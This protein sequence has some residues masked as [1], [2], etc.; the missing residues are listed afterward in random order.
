MYF[1]NRDDN[2][3]DA[4]FLLVSYVLVILSRNT[5]SLQIEK[6]NEKCDTRHKGGSKFLPASGLKEF[7]W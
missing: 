7:C 6:K 5:K 3:R 4:A 2:T 1:A